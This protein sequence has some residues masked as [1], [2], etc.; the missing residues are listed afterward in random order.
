MFK[1]KAIRNISIVVLVIAG[2]LVAAYFYGPDSKN[3]VERR[4]SQLQ[5]DSIALQGNF[6]PH[7]SYSF[8]SDILTDFEKIGDLGKPLRF[9]SDEVDSIR[10]FSNPRTA[11]L[12]NYNISKCDSVLSYVSPMWRATAAL[13]LGRILKSENEYSV[14]RMNKEYERN[15][16]VEIYSA[17]YMSKDEIEKSAKEYN[18]ILRR[19]GFKSVIYSFSPV[20]SGWEYTFD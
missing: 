3:A 7:G 12:A 19:L 8:M 4:I 6:V 16:G 11:A 18:S 1:N 9:S 13:T 10:M 20:T 2:W 14:V 17:R 5:N 15:T